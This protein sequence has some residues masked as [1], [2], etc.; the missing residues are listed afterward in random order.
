MQSANDRPFVRGSTAQSAA[1]RIHSKSI[2]RNNGW[3]GFRIP[4]GSV[5]NGEP[6]N[7]AIWVDGGIH[8]R[9]WASPAA[10]T[11][12]LNHIVENWDSLPKF[13]TNKEWY[14]TRQLTTIST[15]LTR[16][17][18]A[19]K[20]QVHPATGQSRRLRIHTYDRSHV[21][22]KSKYRSRWTLRRCRSES[23]LRLQIRRTGD[24]GFT[25]WTHF[26]RTTCLLR[27]RNDG[28]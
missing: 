27:T 12:T 6:G 20:S 24:I 22:Q 7:K 25:M 3:N 11:F 2:A 4:H 1:V 8:A 13:V 16:T 10:V 17:Y 21:A 14:A 9:E 5:S 26:S 28:T 15:H 23:K 18:F 19:I